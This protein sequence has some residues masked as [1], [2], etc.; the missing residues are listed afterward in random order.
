MK[1]NIYNKTANDY[2]LDQKFILMTNI[3]LDFNLKSE[4]NLRKKNYLNALDTSLEFAHCINPFSTKTAEGYKTCESIDAQCNDTSLRE[5]DIEDIVAEKEF[6]DTKLELQNKERISQDAAR[7]AQLQKLD[8]DKQNRILQAQAAQASKARRRYGGA[9]STP[10]DFPHF[11]QAASLILVFTLSLFLTERTISKSAPAS[12][13]APVPANILAI[14]FLTFYTLLSLLWTSFGVVPFRSFLLH[15]ILLYTSIAP[16]VTF[17][18]TFFKKKPHLVF[19]AAF[20][21]ALVPF[22]VSD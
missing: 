21:I 19:L 2:D 16:V 12:A 8:A 5:E 14:T 20:V 1:H 4:N 6:A 10:E 7:N 15:L 17:A 22:F 13:P 11:I 9:L 3:R 18:P